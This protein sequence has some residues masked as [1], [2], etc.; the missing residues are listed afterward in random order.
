MSDR[1]GDEVRDL[2]AIRA[3]QRCEFC[4]IQKTQAKARLP[5]SSVP[6]CFRLNS[7]GLLEESKA[8]DSL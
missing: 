3:E 7:Q 8:G 5:G 6:A 1:I 4:L 2:V